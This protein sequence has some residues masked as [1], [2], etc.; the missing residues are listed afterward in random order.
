ML[1]FK[2]KRRIVKIASLDQI[3]TTPATFLKDILA[4]VGN[5]LASVKYKRRNETIMSTYITNLTKS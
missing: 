3:M 5:F 4:G 1:S 2:F